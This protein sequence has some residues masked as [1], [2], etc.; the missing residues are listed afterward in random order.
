MHGR[1]VHFF[2]AIVNVNNVNQC[3]CSPQKPQ[4]NQLSFKFEK[5]YAWLAWLVGLASLFACCFVPFSLLLFRIRV[6]TL[7]SSP[8]ALYHSTGSFCAQQFTR[9]GR[10]S[11]LVVGT[12]VVRCLVLFS[13]AAQSRLLAAVSGAEARP[14]EPRRYRSMSRSTRKTCSAAGYILTALLAPHTSGPRDVPRCG[15]LSLL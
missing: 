1:C 11:L 7:L 4:H 10:Y 15:T 12:C 6:A 8:E 2:R 9:A 14:A 13:R 5:P 3:A